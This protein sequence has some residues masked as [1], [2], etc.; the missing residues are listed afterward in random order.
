MDTTGD[1]LSELKE[2]LLAELERSWIGQFV[3]GLNLLLWEKG[4]IDVG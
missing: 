2:V 1:E 4:W 3:E